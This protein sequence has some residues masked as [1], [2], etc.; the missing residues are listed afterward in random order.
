MAKKTVAYLRTT[1][2]AHEDVYKQNPDSEKKDM[3]LVA[4]KG[5]PN[6]DTATYT[7]P[8]WSDELERWID[9]AV[10]TNGTSN[11]EWKLVNERALP[12][13]FKPTNILK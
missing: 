3:I 10:D 9:H 8:W 4:A 12:K 1:Q 11:T 7:G 13:D 2:I 5:E 6:S